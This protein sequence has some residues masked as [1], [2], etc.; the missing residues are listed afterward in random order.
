MESFFPVL[1]PVIV[2]I[3]SDTVP[4][5][6]REIIALCVFQILPRGLMTNIESGVLLILNRDSLE[7]CGRRHS[8]GETVQY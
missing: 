5:L 1:I 2:N 4:S 3:A 6:P 8:V 7:N